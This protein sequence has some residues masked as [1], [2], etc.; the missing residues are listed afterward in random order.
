MANHILHKKYVEFSFEDF[1]Q[2]DFFI[3]SIKNPTPETLVYWNKFCERNENI[4]NYTAA[5]DCIESINAYNYILSP[6]SAEQIRKSIHQ[7]INRKKRIPQL[8]YWGVGAAACVVLLMVIPFWVMKKKEVPELKP[9]IESFADMT[10]YRN[11]ATEIQL[12]L[13]D[14]QTILLEREETIITY[15]TTGIIV[16]KKA[17]AQDETTGF[18]QLIVPLGKRSVLNLS[19]GTKVWVNSD[20][21]LIYPVAFAEDSR[22]IFVDGEIYI[23]VVADAQRP[24]IVKTKDLDVQ[25]LGTKFNVMAY[26]A[27]NE[28]KIVLVSGS[29]QIKSKMEANITRLSP[30]QMYTVQDGQSQVQ[31]VDTEKYIS[32]INGIYYC[33]DEGLG[34]ILQRLSRYYGTEISCEPSISGVMFSGKLDLKDNLSEIFNNI[35]FSLPISYIEEDGKYMISKLK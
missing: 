10:R 15:D 17:I 16:D 13:S 35:S 1:L 34:S 27:D 11:K 28:K 4:E 25:V 6:Q 30:D 20:T 14:K 31:T 5:K 8:S 9:D 29:V 19:D 2:D 3:S 18:N 21:R 32:W 33:Q 23:D 22:E 7:K 24:F 12:V 26:D